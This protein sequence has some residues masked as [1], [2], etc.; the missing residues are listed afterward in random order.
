MDDDVPYLLL[1]P[2][3]LTTSRS[4]RH[5]MRRDWCIWDA[6]YNSIVSRIVTSFP[7]ILPNLSTQSI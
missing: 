3:P 6:D 1:T 7:L 5:A 2:G 4:V